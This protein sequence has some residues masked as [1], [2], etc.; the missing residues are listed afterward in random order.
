MF[1]E[2]NLSDR[3]RHKSMQKFHGRMAR[4]VHLTK[5]AKK[6]YE[7]NL[8]DLYESYQYFNSSFPPDFLYYEDGRW[9]YSRGWLELNRNF[10][11]LG[12]LTEWGE[13]VYPRI[14]VSST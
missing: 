11:E 5:P 13:R 8:L 10:R 7:R 1:F 9:D 4:K 14:P 6:N 3:D 12:F 2:T